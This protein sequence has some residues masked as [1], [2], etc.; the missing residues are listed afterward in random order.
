M[1]VSQMLV[2]MAKHFRVLMFR[3]TQCY[4]NETWRRGFR[5]GAVLIQIVF[6]CKERVYV[7]YI[8]HRGSM[9]IPKQ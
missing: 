2:L 1:M 4:F 7:S 3:V 5:A 8:K 6:N 9:C